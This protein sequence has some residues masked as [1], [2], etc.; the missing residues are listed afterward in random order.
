MQMAALSCY[1]GVCLQHFPP[2]PLP[3]PRGRLIEHVYEAE[4]KITERSHNRIYQILSAPSFEKTQAPERGNGQYWMLFLCCVGIYC[5]IGPNVLF[6]YRF[7]WSWYDLKY[8]SP[9]LFL[10]VQKPNS[11]EYNFVEVSGHNLERSQTYGFPYTVQF[12]K[13]KTFVQ[14][15]SKNSASGQL[16]RHT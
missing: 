4:Y 14:I 12:G 3:H 16:L 8:T 7:L 10:I 11:W 1:R 15:T 2:P 6:L 13:K 9:Q 5:I